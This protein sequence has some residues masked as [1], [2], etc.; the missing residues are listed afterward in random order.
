MFV[1]AMLDLGLPL[2]KL[3]S[4]LKKSPRFVQL[5]VSKKSV[6][7]IRATHFHVVCPDQESARSWKQIRT[8]DRRQQSPPQVK[9]TGIEYFR[10]SQKPRERST[11]LPPKK[12]TFTKSAPRIQSSTSWPQRSAPTNS[13]SMPSIFPAIPLGRGLTRAPHGPL[14][15]PGPATLNS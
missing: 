8:L 2:I 1:G 15:V 3:K 5:T 10:A 11:A 7:S 13:P 6:H 4:E 12:F 14:P 9:E